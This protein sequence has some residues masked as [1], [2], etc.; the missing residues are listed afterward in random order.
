MSE[1]HLFECR[2]RWTGAGAKTFTYDLLSRDLRV[3]IIDKPALDLSSAPQFHGDPMRHNPEDLMMAALSSCHALT[4]LAVAARSRIEVVGY[5]DGASGFLEKKD[6][7]MRFTEA[8]LRPRVTVARGTDLERAKALH[9][10]AHQNCFI[11]QSV[12]FPVR[13]EAEVLEAE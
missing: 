3:T 4:Y 7:P 12:N 10:K 13:I 11:A 1:R 6:G 9:E 5:E 8:T 2:L